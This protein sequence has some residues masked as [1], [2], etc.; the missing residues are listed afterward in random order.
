MN[1][2]LKRFLEDVPLCQWE[3]LGKGYL[4]AKLCIKEGTRVLRRL[5]AAFSE[6]QT[7]L[8]SLGNKKEWSQVPDLDGRL[9]DWE[10]WLATREGVSEV[11]VMEEMLEL[12]VKALRQVVVLEDAVPCHVLQYFGE[13]WAS[14]GQPPPTPPLSSPSSLLSRRTSLMYHSTAHRGGL[15]IAGV[16]NLAS[17]IKG[18]AKFE[19]KVQFYKEDKEDG[20]P[21]GVVM[22][23]EAE[24]IIDASES[25]DDEGTK[26]SESDDDDDGNEI[27][28][29]EPDFPPLAASTPLASLNGLDADLSSGNEDSSSSG[30]DW[31]LGN[32]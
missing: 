24:T 14:L 17:G 6:M 27:F 22:A 13:E 5:N 10:D 25:D 1:K 2:Q 3:S 28:S 19:E 20:K 9:R 16:K 30:S 23:H 32:H 26:I 21:L 29:F 8:G 18:P 15:D 31:L 11:E 4:G 7:L 12:L